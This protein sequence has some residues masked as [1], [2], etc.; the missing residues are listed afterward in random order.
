VDHDR[1]KQ[2]KVHPIIIRIFFMDDEQMGSLMLMYESKKLKTLFN[3]YPRINFY[4]CQAKCLK[5]TPPP[6]ETRYGTGYVGQDFRRS[7]GES[8]VF[9]QQMVES[10]PKIV[11]TPQLY[12]LGNYM[13][14]EISLVGRFVSK[15]Y[16]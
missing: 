6:G 5:R 16:N 7:E 3:A 11:G 15:A 14:V 1:K 2:K 4:K 12:G 8:D 9:I 10:G 13:P